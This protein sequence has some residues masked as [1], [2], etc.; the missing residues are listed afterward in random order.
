MCHRVKGS[1]TLPGVQL[2]FRPRKRNATGNP[3]IVNFSP[4]ERWKRGGRG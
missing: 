1:A 4:P 2:L 3:R